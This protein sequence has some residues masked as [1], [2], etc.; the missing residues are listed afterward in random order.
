MTKP[1]KVNEDDEDKSDD[2]GDNDV[3]EQG[4]GPKPAEQVARMICDWIIAH[5]LDQTLTHLG[6]D[7]TSSNTGWRRGVIAWMEKIL[8]KKF[9][10]LICMLHTNELGLRKLM[11][12]L[13]GKTCSK[14]GFS[15]PLG[16][17]LDKVKYMQPNFAFKKIE[18]GP[19]VPE[20]P[21]DVEKDLSR[22]QKVLYKRWKAVKTG[23][24]PKE[25]ALYKSGPIVHSRWL[26][27]ADTILQ[28]HMSKHNLEG[29]L[30]LRL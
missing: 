3:E 23:I 6:A 18:L 29:E 20:L 10:W 15:G 7:S 30:L 8:G 12:A 11:A 28:M 25:V 24:L 17:L 14:T 21:D 27:F 2:E 22:D 5:G 26:T 16:K 9:H 19:E 13:D 1:G 4:S